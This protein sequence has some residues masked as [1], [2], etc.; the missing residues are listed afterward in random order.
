MGKAAARQSGKERYHGS[1]HRA[2]EVTL[3]PTSL[4]PRVRL[5]S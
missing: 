3:T 2:I 4:P 5:E 1:L